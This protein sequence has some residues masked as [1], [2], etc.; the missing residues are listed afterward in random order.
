MVCGAYDVLDGLKKHLGVNVGET[1]KDGKFHLME[2]RP[3]PPPFLCCPL[4]STIALC[5]VRCAR[6]CA[7]S[8]SVSVCILF[9]RLPSHV[10]QTADGVGL[11]LIGVHR[12]SVLARAA[13]RR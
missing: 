6:A 7:L 8:V 1:T 3:P 4:L 10:W 5:F 12:P 11:L 2:A 9:T 13:T